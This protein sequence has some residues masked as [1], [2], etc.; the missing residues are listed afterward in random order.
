MEAIQYS[1]SEDYLEFIEKPIPRIVETTDVLI[2]VLFC[3]ISKADVK[4]IDGE[5]PCRAHEPFIMGREICG[6]VIGVGTEV[7]VVTPGDHAVVQPNTFC[8]ICN[9]CRMGTPHLCSHCRVDNALGVYLSGGWAEFIVVPQT[10]VYR[11]D[12]NFAVELGVLV[13]TMA[14]LIQGFEALG[15]ISF[16]QKIIVYGAGITGIL[17]IAFLH[18]KGCRNVI[19]CEPNLNRHEIVQRMDVNFEVISPIISAQRIVEDTDFVF[20]LIFDCSSCTKVLEQAFQLVNVGG[21]IVILNN[22][23]VSEKIRFSPFDFQTKET[24]MIGI[25]ASSFKFGKAI[26]ALGML[27]KRYLTYERVGIKMYPLRCYKEAVDHVRKGSVIKAVFRMPDDFFVYIHISH[28]NDE[29]KHAKNRSLYVKTRKFSTNFAEI[30]RKMLKY[31]AVY[32]SP[33]KISNL[34]IRIKI[35]EN[36]ENVDDQIISWQQKVF[37][38]FER[39]FYRDKRNCHNDLEKKYHEEVSKGVRDDYIIFSYVNGDEYSDGTDGEVMHFMADLNDFEPTLLCTIVYDDTRHLFT[40]FPDFTQS[41]PYSLQIETD[42]KKIFQYYIEDASEQMP[43]EVQLKETE[44]LN[45]ITSH[46]LKVR[47]KKA[48]TD[49]EI[50]SKN[51][52]NFYLFCEI[53]CCRNFEYNDIYVQYLIDLPEHWSCPDVSCLKGCT[54]TSHSSTSDGLSYFGFPFELHLECNLFEL[55]EDEIARQPCMYLEVVSKDTW[56]RFRSEGVAYTLLP[57]SQ[58]G[59]HNYELRCV[60]TCPTGTKGNLRRFF[61]GDYTNGNMNWAGVPED[62]EARRRAEGDENDTQLKQKNSI[63]KCAIVTVATGQINIRINVLQQS[64][65]FAD[66]PTATKKRTQFILEKLNTSGLIKSVEQVVAAFKIAK[67]KMI[68]AKKNI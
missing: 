40:I 16:D 33:D 1:K 49:F 48:G 31:T 15:P 36:D 5:Y 13:P 39:N 66:E 34:K 9:G 38:K 17:C 61:V 4:I 18:H 44:I 20:D 52:L 24:T 64:Q 54:F 67:R 27:N 63:N 51:T 50:P 62:H 10:Q 28:A 46:Q 19:V 56:H 7:L 25:S 59:V 41:E 11:L 23:P 29:Y 37:G 45:K 35:K 60:R 14:N 47:S 3:G 22:K 6:M 43:L 65:A 55:A 68:E 30:I 42:T 26:A 58:S 21:K 12:E 57:I 53:L 8:E 2:R 32:N